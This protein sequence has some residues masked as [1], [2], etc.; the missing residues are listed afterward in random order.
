MIAGGADFL[1]LG[2]CF[3]FAAG[4]GWGVAGFC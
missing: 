2:G 3:G 4:H 1:G